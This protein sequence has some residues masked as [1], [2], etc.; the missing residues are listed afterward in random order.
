M[1]GF[2]GKCKFS[3]FSVV[4]LDNMES[5]SDF[6]EM[7]HSGADVLKR[8]RTEQLLADLCKISVIKIF[9]HVHK[10]PP[11]LES[12]FNKVAELNV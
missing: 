4:F 3:F 1:T 7:L 8:I 12:L 6:A 5:E 2:L 11:V 10:E 9:C